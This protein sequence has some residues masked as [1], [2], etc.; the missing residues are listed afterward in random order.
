MQMLSSW[1]K[2]HPF[3]SFILGA[4]L[5]LASNKI[6]EFAGK[7]SFITGSVIIFVNKIDGLKKMIDEYHKRKK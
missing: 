2:R 4:V 6:G 7:L 5:M 3:I 1:I